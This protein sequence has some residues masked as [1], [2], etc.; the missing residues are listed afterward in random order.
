MFRRCCESRAGL[1]GVPMRQMPDVIFNLEIGHAFW[2]QGG[3]KGVMSS[4]VCVA[5]DRSLR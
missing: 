3:E 4:G 5:G 1:R 2:K